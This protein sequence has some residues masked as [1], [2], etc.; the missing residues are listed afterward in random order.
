MNIAVQKEASENLK[1]IAYVEYLADH[2]YVP[3]GGKSWV[4]HIRQKGN[5][6]THEIKLMDKQDA[7]DL[8]KFSEML[9]KFIYEFPGLLPQPV[10]Q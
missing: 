3:P 10:E 5:E 7:E 8:I 6:A 1:F 4:D 2:G 9:L